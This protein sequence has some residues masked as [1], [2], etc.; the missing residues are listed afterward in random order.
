ME[1]EEALKLLRSSLSANIEIKQ[2]ISADCCPVLADPTQV[3]Q[4]LMNLCTN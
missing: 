1:R 3:H 2:K 4:V